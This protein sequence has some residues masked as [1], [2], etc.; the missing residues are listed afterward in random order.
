MVVC[1]FFLRGNC[2]FGPSCKN[3]HPSKPVSAPFS[4][5]PPDLLPLTNVIP[6][7]NKSDL[8]SQLSDQLMRSPV[9]HL[10]NQIRA[11]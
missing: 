6:G 8:I 4:F 2:S 7:W 5:V 1:Q 9:M 10:G 3:E 11:Y